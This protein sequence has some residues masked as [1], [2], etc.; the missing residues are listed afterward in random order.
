ML[1]HSAIISDL[2]EM[3][4]FSSTVWHSIL[5]GFGHFGDLIIVV[6]NK[7]R[8]KTLSCLVFFCAYSFYFLLAYLP[9][10][11]KFSQEID[12]VSAPYSRRTKGLMLCKHF[13]SLVMIFPCL[14]LL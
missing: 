13:L 5:P 14:L 10:K 11:S 1:C 9:S 2:I 12:L 6:L 4:L 7:H 3:F 8:L